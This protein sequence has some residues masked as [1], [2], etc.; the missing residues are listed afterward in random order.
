MIL[1]NVKRDK[2]GKRKRK[3]G[4]GTTV[5]HFPLHASISIPYIVLRALQI[6]A[7]ELFDIV[8]PCGKTLHISVLFI[9]CNLGINLCGSDIFMP[10]H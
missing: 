7:G 9:P 3:R 2:K 4:Q 1:K 8:Q 6:A 10:K 5:S